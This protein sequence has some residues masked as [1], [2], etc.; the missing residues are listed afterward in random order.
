MKTKEERYSAQLAKYFEKVILNRSNNFYAKKLRQ[1]HFEQRID[2]S[3]PTF[4]DLETI[5]E[6]IDIP[7][8]VIFN[9]KLHVDNDELE[10]ALQTINEREKFFIVSKFVFDLTDQE[11]GQLLGISRQAVTNFKHRLY[12]KIR[13]RMN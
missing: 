1:N 5:D 7:N 11:I 9:V 8:V 6:N 13:K 10:M 3:S 2:D 12:T 4:I